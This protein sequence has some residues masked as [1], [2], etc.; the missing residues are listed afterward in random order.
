[1]KQFRNNIQ[2]SKAALQDEWI[3]HRSILKVFWKE[4]RAHS[5]EQRTTACFERQTGGD[6][7]ADSA[8]EGVDDDCPESVHGD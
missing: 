5:V 7:A 3:T 8:N 4:A 2:Y 1:M 6:D